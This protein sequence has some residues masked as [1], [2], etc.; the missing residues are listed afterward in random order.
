MIPALIRTIFS[1]PDAEYVH[2]QHGEI[3]LVLERIYPN[4]SELVGDAREDPLAC[5]NFPQAQ[6]PQIW[7]ANPSDHLNREFERRTNVIG[8]FPK[9]E[10]LLKTT[11]AVLMEQHVEW[12]AAKGWHLAEGRLSNL[13]QP[14]EVD[15][16]RHGNYDYRLCC[17]FQT[18]R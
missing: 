15:E 12:A 3:R 13:S 2:T 5:A 9:P 1:Q 4:T 7:S 14:A 10:A 11:V 18:R 8:V 16:G 6:E 17:G